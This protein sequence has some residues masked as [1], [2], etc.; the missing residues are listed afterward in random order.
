EL[1]APRVA[2]GAIRRTLCIAAWR[3]ATG[4]PARWHG[5]AAQNAPASQASRAG[6]C[7]RRRHYLF[8]AR[9]GRVGSRGTDALSVEYDPVL[10]PTN[11]P[12]ALRGS[13]GA[14]RHD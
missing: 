13:V 9:A 5:L 14:C 3:V 7:A 11:W 1:L 8:T 12:C 10:V 4:R 2:R 6:H